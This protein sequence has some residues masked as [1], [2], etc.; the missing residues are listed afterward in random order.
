MAIRY[1]YKN[2]KSFVYPNHKFVSNFE[3]AEGEDAEAQFCDAFAE[4]CEKNGLSINYV[5]QTFP[6]VLRMLGTDN[7]WTRMEKGK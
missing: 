7:G 6:S 4:L 5:Y 3:F 1:E 2:G